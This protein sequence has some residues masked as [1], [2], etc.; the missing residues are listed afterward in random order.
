MRLV[1]CLAC[2]QSKT[3]VF[4]SER[5]SL[6]GMTH[7][8][9][10][11][12]FLITH[13]LFGCFCRVRIMTG[14]TFHPPFFHFV[15]VRQTE[16]S[17][18]ILMAN[19]ANLF[20][21]MGEQSLF[22]SFLMQGMTGETRLPSQDMLFPVDIFHEM[23]TFMARK[24]SGVDFSR[25]SVSEVTDRTLNFRIINMDTSGSVAGFTVFNRLIVFIHCRLKMYG[26]V[27]TTEHVIVTFQTGFGT[28]VFFG[29]LLMGESCSNTTADKRCFLFFTVIA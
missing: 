28:D 25:R 26:L 22:W 2:S 17:N 18:F 23:I 24:A 29:C 13:T 9:V 11:R 19:E 15:M 12:Y 8:T 16:I 4:V 21:F 7:Q 1:T 20:R 14:P 3:K 10:F 27:Y 6:C 5:A